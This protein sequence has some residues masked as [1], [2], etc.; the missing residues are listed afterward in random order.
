MHFAESSFLCRMEIK[1]FWLARCFYLVQICDVISKWEQALKEL[2][3]GK[4]EGTRI[5]RLIY[6]SRFVVLFRIC[7]LNNVC[8]VHVVIWFNLAFRLCFRAQAKGETERERLLL[9]CQVN[10]E[11]QQGHFPVSKELGL[12]VAALMAQVGAIESLCMFRQGY[13]RFLESNALNK[14]YLLDWAWWFRSIC[15]VS[16]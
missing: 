6:K 14:M 3:P 11:V 12:E 9:A 1:Q 13:L 4:Y 7:Q 5:V 2:H 16:C 15:S 10:E 8:P